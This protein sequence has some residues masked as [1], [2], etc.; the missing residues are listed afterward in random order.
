MVDVSSSVGQLETAGKMWL[1]LDHII[2]IVSCEVCYPFPITADQ[3]SKVVKGEHIV[4]VLPFSI[5]L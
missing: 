3:N 5:V 4:F 1:A 2:G